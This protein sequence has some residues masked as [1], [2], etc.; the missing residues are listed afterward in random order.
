[1]QHLRGADD[2]VV[3]FLRLFATASTVAGFSTLDSVELRQILVEDDLRVMHFHALN[4]TLALDALLSDIKSN[5][6]N[7]SHS[8]IYAFTLHMRVEPRPSPLSK[9]DGLRLILTR[10]RILGIRVALRD[11]H[12]DRLVSILVLGALAQLH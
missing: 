3:G 8:P 10:R 1:M 12:T 11:G 6:V 9:R 2:A 4:S 7:L 5:V